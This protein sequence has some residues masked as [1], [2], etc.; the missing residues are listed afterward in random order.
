MCRECA[1]FSRRH[2]FKTAAAGFVAA[3]ASPLALPAFAKEAAKEAPEGLSAEAALARLA[4]GNAIYVK[5]PQLCMVNLAADRAKVANGQ[6]PWASILTCSDS[7]VIPEIIFGGLDF[8][9]LF[10]ARNAGNL[11]NTDVLGSLEYA[12]EHLGTKLIVVLGHSRCGAVSAACDVL[13]KGA[14]L[15][16]NIKLMV[17]E[18]LPAAQAVQGKPGD[19]VDNAV[20]EN[21]RRNAEIIATS[22]AISK[23]VKAAEVKVV[24]GRYDLDSGAVAFLG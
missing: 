6:K 14:K 12:S 15:E 11:A 9:E 4:S 7:R 3:A 17:D 24:Y 21:A 18:I 22:Q 2:F 20:R 19:F 8:G 13:A 1:R 23:M 16:G 5:S 10:V